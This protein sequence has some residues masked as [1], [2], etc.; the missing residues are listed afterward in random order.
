[1]KDTHETNLPA[2]E[3]GKLEEAKAPVATPER[4]AEENGINEVPKAEE[5]TE[6]TSVVKVDTPLITADEE[7]SV[8]EGKLSK[9]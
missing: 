5:T 1:M 3:V 2:E 6:E 4:T 8:V 7:D 9:D